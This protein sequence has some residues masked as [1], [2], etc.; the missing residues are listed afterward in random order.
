MSEHRALATTRPF[1]APARIG[2]TLRWYKEGILQERT[3][4]Y[5][6]GCSLWHPDDSSTLTTNTGT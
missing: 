5:P 6:R 4:E 1:Q 2:V 3:Q